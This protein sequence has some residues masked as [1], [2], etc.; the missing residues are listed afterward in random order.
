MTRSHIAS[1]VNFLGALLVDEQA[2]QMSIAP[3]EST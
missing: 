2:T 1:A 3:T